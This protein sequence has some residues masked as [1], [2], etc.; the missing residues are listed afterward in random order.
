VPAGRFVEVYTYAPLEVCET[1]DPK[2][3][4][5]KARAGKIPEFTGISA[6]YEEPLNAELVVDTSKCNPTEAAE[7]II[8]KLQE[9]GLLM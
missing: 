8:K 4:Y 3:L 6:P 1:R 2:G 7:I 9:M 5:K